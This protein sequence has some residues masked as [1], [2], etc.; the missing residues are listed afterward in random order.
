M[1][2]VT[3]SAYLPP[4][5]DPHGPQ[6][7]EGI[8]DVFGA[9]SGRGGREKGRGGGGGVEGSMGGTHCRREMGR[10][11]M[12]GGVGGGGLREG[13]GRVQGG[14]PRALSQ[15]TQRLDDD[16]TRLPQEQQM[17]R[18]TGGGGRG[19]GDAAWRPSVSHNCRFHIW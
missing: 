19:G 17:M 16:L 4:L 18:K 10:D 2:C 11:R 6:G 13:A 8:G 7:G 12:G 3:Q 1:G 14:Q 15:F 5:H 9:D